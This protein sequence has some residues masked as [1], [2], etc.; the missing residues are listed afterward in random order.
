MNRCLR[1][2]VMEAQLPNFKK[3]VSEDDIEAAK[4]KRQEE[5]EKVRRPDQPE[6]APEEEY[7]PRSLFERLE[8]NRLKKQEEFDEAHRLKNMVKGLENDEIEFL[9][10]VSQLKEK[11]EI[12]KEIEERVLLAEYKSSLVRDITAEQEQELSSVLARPIHP[13]AQFVFCCC[14]QLVGRQGRR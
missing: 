7:D 11:Q 5:W 14:I 8:A 2:R 13:S 1:S 4:K 6:E 12:E 9:E 10:Q 3:F